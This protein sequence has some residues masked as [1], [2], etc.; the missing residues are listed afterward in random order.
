MI[1]PVQLKSKMLKLRKNLKGTQML[2]KLGKKVQWVKRISQRMEAWLFRES[3]VSQMRWRM[4]MKVHIPLSVSLIEMTEYP[5]P[6]V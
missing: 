3:Q 1:N 5:S 6:N 2:P 4:K